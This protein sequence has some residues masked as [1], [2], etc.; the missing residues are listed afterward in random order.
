MEHEGNAYQAEG[1]VQKG[2]GTAKDALKGGKH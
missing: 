2:V 1:K